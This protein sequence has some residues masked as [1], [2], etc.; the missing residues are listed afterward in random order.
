M[1]VICFP[2]SYTARPGQ[3]FALDLA[4]LD[5]FDNP[6]IFVFGFTHLNGERTVPAGRVAQYVD[7]S[8]SQ[9]V[10]MSPEITLYCTC[11]CTNLC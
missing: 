2:Q 10:R 1:N 3:K 4:P 8:D 6:T 5:L 7:L 11:L 9:D